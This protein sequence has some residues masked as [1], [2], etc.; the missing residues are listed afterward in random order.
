MGSIRSSAY[1]SAEFTVANAASN[2]DVRE[3]E[4]DAF[5]NVPVSVRTLIRTD[6]P[7]TIKLNSTANPGI[8]I[9]LQ[10]NPLVI[11]WQEIKDIFITNASGST[12]NIK[13]ILVE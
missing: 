12:A 8:T 3:E 10:D 6:Q 2:Y 1:D 13:L 11:D 7:V 9:N 5:S 4:S